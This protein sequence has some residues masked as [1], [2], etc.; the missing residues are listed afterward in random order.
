[1]TKNYEKTLEECKR[2][3]GEQRE[4]L[5]QDVVKCLTGPTDMKALQAL[6]K[7]ELQAI[8]KNHIEEN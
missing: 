5:M 2:Y 7:E 8:I 4:K 1:M 6:S 3:E